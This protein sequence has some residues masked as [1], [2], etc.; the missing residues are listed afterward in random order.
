MVD[1]EADLV[2]TLSQHLQRERP[3]VDFKGFSNPV[4][5]LQEINAYPPDLLITDLRMP[6]INGLELVLVARQR[7][8]DLRVVLIT[9]FGSESARAEARRLGSVEFVEKPFDLQDLLKHIDGA[10]ANG[11]RFSGEISLP[12][13]SDLIQIVALSRETG[14]LSVIHGDEGGKVWFADG[15][16]VHCEVGE[17]VGAKAFQKL[18]SWNNGEFRMSLGEESP[19]QTIDESIDHLLLDSLTALDEEAAGVGRPTEDGSEGEAIVHPEAEGRTSPVESARA[20]WQRCPMS[21]E[22]P[23]ACW[24][25]AMSLR[26]GTAQVLHG[27]GRGDRSVPF[28]DWLFD[29]MESALLLQPGRRT[30]RLEAVEQ[31]LGW[32]VGWNADKELALV[33]AQLAGGPAGLVAFRANGAGVTRVL[34]G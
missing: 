14:A 31:D 15:N 27:S 19:E 23:A 11:E 13:F 22:L 26:D 1:D 30:G 6:G 18:L 28:G 34:L 9:A 20:R 7:V 3:E 29:L 8:P 25:L 32:C 2:W 5:A 21:R 12:L 33:F 4:E 24:L 10:L 16:L 17:M